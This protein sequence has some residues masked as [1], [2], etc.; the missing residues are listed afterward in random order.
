MF[1][2]VKYAK[3][4]SRNAHYMVKDGVGGGGS[5]SGGGVKVDIK[6]TRRDSLGATTTLAPLPSPPHTPPPY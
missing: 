5:G 1:L 3:S 4:I 2:P 6:T